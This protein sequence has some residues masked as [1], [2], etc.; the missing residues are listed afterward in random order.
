[1]LLQEKKYH[2]ASFT[3]IKKILKAIGVKSEPQIV[4]MHY[5]AHTKED[6]VIKLVVYKDKNEIHI[7]EKSE[8]KFIFK[9]HIA[10]KNT[11]AG[12]HWLKEH[13]YKTV[14]VVKM[15][16]NDYVYKEGKIELYVLEDFLYSVILYYP[17]GKH[18]EIEKELRLTES[19]QI[20]IPYNKYLDSL[21]KL[22]S[23]E[24]D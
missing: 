1:M 9:E 15:I 2:V 23:T 6:E 24:L 21:E 19:E 17:E 12:F 11:K 3:A 14:D 5:Y 7:L 8:G 13:G 10:V 20:Q 22:R 18:E 16:N 4:S